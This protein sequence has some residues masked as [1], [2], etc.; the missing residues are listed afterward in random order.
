MTASLKQLVMSQENNPVIKPWNILPRSHHEIQIALCP[1]IK[2]P[3][4]NSRGK[5]KKKRVLGK[6]NLEIFVTK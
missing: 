3:S 6:K 1:K 2:E 5:K 4:K